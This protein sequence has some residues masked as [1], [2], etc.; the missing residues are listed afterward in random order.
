[1]EKGAI[2]NIQKGDKYGKNRNIKKRLYRKYILQEGNYI[3]TKY[4]QGENEYKNAEMI[5]GKK[6]I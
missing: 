6:Y 4:R 1:M 5:Y 3:D 2:Q